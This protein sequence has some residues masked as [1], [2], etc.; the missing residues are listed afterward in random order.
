MDT[1]TAIASDQDVLAAIANRRWMVVETNAMT[2]N[3]ESTLYKRFTRAVARVESVFSEFCEN[4]PNLDDILAAADDDAYDA[5]IAFNDYMNG[6]HQILIA[7]SVV[8]DK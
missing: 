8:H 5:V 3:T 2:G 1:N 7:E 4:D 6:E